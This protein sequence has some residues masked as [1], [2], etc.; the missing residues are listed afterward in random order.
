MKPLTLYK[1]LY[2]HFGPQYWWPGQSKFE[3][4]VGAIL[5]QNTAWG[6]V[7]K[8]IN[9]LKREN[10]LSISKILAMHQKS[11]AK[12]IKPSGYYN[13]K[14]KKLKAFCKHI[15]LNYDGNLKSFLKKPT[16]ELREELLSLYG[17]GQETADSI[18]LYAA[19]KPIFV[20]DAYT[21]RFVLRFYTKTGLSYVEAQTLF[22]SQ[23]PKDEKLFNEFHALLVEFGKNYCKKK[24]ECSR[25]FL[26]KECSYA[27]PS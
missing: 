6:N 25:C 19:E 7:E 17:I 1:T 10:A 9:N 18:I 22:E 15:E 13:Q 5:T 26:N 11:V 12:L 3:V 24:P 2:S 8:T 20:V 23:L 4:C 16:K 14:A 21:V 27:K